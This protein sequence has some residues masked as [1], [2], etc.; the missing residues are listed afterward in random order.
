M[1]R[2]DQENP[3][4]QDFL[5][6]GR[7][8]ASC[9]EVRR[10][11]CVPSSQM[12]RQQSKEI[13]R[14][15]KLLQPDMYSAD[16]HVSSQHYAD[17]MA[18]VK[19]NILEAVQRPA[20]S[21]P[22]LYSNNGLPYGSSAFAA[23]VGRLRPD[24]NHSGGR[25]QFFP[26]NSSQEKRGL[27]GNVHD[28]YQLMHAGGHGNYASNCNSTANSAPD[29]SG[30]G[31]MVFPF[32]APHLH[33]QSSTARVHQIPF[34][35]SQAQTFPLLVGGVSP[36]RMQPAD[37]SI[38]PNSSQLTIFYAGRVNVFDDVSSIKAEE[39]MVMAASGISLS[40][41]MA[42]FSGTPVQMIP[43]P[44]SG[45]L[46]NADAAEFS[47]MDPSTCQ[48]DQIARDQVAIGP[49]LPTNSIPQAPQTEESYTPGTQSTYIDNETACPQALP[50]A[51][52][53]SLTRFL[54]RRKERVLTN[55][56]YPVEKSFL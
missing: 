56:P 52:K 25:Q 29:P 1:G 9:A 16:S 18:V 45:S 30:S 41:N 23:A 27:V 48:P 3:R 22:R 50:Q 17:A 38:K 49:P 33:E 6:L 39:I 37:S 19:S 11:G 24:S 51:R 54:Q 35:R 26:F 5:G 8:V 55:S 42:M 32:V 21:S 53:A 2:S 43:P 13:Y 10:H 44:P 31:M 7:E 46:K 36:A 34:A 4:E 28:A 15:H 47:R 12:R 40:S 14:D 20:A